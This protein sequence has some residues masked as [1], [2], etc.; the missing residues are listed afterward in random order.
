MFHFMVVNYCLGIPGT[1]PTRPLIG[2]NTTSFTIS[3]DVGLFNLTV[4][5]NETVGQETVLRVVFA[6]GIPVPVGK[7]IDC[8]FHSWWKLLCW[9]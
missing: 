3:E 6:G 9:L 5:S 4:I 2:F 1:A 7:Q 8:H